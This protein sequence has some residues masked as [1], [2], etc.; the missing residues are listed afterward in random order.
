MSTVRLSTLAGKPVEVSADVVD[1]VRNSLRG[2]MLTPGET[3]YDEARAVWNAMID[4]RPGLICRC[5]GAGDVIQAVRF[6][7]KHGLLIAVKGAGHNIAGSAVCD[8][9]LMIDL[10]R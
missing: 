7:R 6:A 2:S 10:L 5:A 4:K 3:G 1:A 9:G 8:G